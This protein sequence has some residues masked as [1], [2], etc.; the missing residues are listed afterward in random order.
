MEGSIFVHALME[1]WTAK[2]C[3]MEPQF[4]LCTNGCHSVEDYEEH[5]YHVDISCN[6]CMS[7]SYH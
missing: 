2:P 3:P 7:G 5:S 1:C 4:D 6:E